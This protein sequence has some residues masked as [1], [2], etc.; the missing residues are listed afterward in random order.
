MEL[1]LYFYNKSS[2]C[3]ACL[4]HRDIFTLP[5]IIFGPYI[6]P[7]VPIGQEAGGPQSWS[8]CGGKE[9]DSHPL[10]RLKLWLSIP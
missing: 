4:K 7:P 5:Y 9:K 6:L 2:W 8:G 10:L 1:H 3:G